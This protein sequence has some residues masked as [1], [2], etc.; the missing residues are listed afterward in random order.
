MTSDKALSALT[1]GGAMIDTIVQI[2][3]E[4]IEQLTMTNA[5]ARYLLVEAGR[6]VEATSIEQHI[7]GG[8]VNAAV[9][10]ARLGART[11][12]LCKL[13]GDLGARKVLERLDEENVATDFVARTG[14]AATGSSVLISSHERNAGVFTARGANTALTADDLP[15]AAFARDLVYVTGL[16]DASADRFPLI[17]EKARAAG[18]FVASNPGIRQL[19]SRA[20]PFFENF[21]N[22]DLL[23][24]NRAEAAQLVPGLVGRGCDASGEVPADIDDP[25]ALIVRGLEA[26]GFHM[27]FRAFVRAVTQAGPRIVLVTDGSRGAWAG[28]ADEIV[29]CATV[30]VEVAGTVGAGDAFASTFALL[31]AEGLP[32]R[33]ALTLATHNAASVIAVVD[34][35]SGLMDRPA[36]QDAASGA[37]PPEIRAWPS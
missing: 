10:M 36:L 15:D 12:C 11:A 29:H 25:E 8:A 20:Q 16:S 14:E 30:P 33:D 1:V 3:P 35:Q 37:A 9:A 28:T 4:R 6:K 26:G 18:A 31:A 21:A 19:S 27:D 22:I 17:L 34:T 24:V 5:E 7:G 2:A 23:S 32:L 13:G